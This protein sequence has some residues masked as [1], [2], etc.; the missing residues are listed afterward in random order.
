MSHEKG[1]ADDVADSARI[2]ESI[3]GRRPRYVAYP[4]GRSTPQVR[5]LIAQL[6]FEAAFAVN[7]GGGPFRAKRVQITPTESSASFALKTSGYYELLRSSR[8]VRRVRDLVRYG[9]RS[10]KDHSSL[11]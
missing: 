10:G 6:G 2:L 8:L 9:A 5:A 7:A 4:Y 1:V 3:T 11:S